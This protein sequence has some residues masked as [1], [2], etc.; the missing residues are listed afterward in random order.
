MKG[1]TNRWIRRRIEPSGVASRLSAADQLNRSASPKPVQHGF[2][3]VCHEFHVSLI[4][5]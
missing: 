2:D 5:V 4:V 3:L 1:L